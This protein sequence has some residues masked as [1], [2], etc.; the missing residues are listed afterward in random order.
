[1]HV[2]N[3]TAHCGEM[4]DNGGYG[5]GGRGVWGA[6]AICY[7]CQLYIGTFCHM[8][9]AFFFFKSIKM[10]GNQFVFEPISCINAIASVL[11]A[12]GL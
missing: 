8:I 3:P 4:V 2:R 11:L 6:A 9:T 1:M 12:I 5:D 10:S 7:A